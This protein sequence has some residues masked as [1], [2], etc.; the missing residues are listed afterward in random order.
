M[1][2]LKMNMAGDIVVGENGDVALTQ[3]VRQQV[4]IRLRWLFGEW[5]FAPEYGVPYFHKILVK[6]PDIDSVKQIIRS[7]IMGVEGMTDVKNLEV[8][9]NSAQ[10]VASI[11]F[12]GYTDG[13][14]FREE[15]ILSA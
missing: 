1:Y 9:I 2:D 6:K 12:D 7:E 3:S 5:R 15:V 8:S 10:R 4:Q 13:E 11:T 14:T